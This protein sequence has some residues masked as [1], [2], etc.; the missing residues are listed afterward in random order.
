MFRVAIFSV[1]AVLIY[2]NP[3]FAHDPWV[4]KQDGK[5]L[6]VFGHINSNEFEML[7]LG[8]IKEAQGI[9]N[10]GRKAEVKMMQNNNAV[11][12]LPEKELSAVTLFMDNGYWVKTTDGSKNISKRE[13][14]KYMDAN[15]YVESSHSIKYSKTILRWHPKLAEPL[16]MRSEIV[17]LK[18]PFGIKTGKV[19]PIRFL[20]EGRPVEGALIEVSGYGKESVTELKTNKEGMADVFIDKPGVLKITAQHKIP[21]KDNPDAD[22]QLIRTT[23][24]FEVK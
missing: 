3:V 16:G 1:L 10:N 8:K 15:E 14:K 21:Q 24:T 23:M 17:P 2:L 4:E 7:E 6:A 19:L 20:F 12:I 22:L 5:L 13:A 18:D 9:D 11:S